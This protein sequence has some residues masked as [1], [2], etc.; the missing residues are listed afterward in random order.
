MEWVEIIGWVAV[1]ATIATYAVRTMLPLRLLALLAN[2]FFLIYGAVT[3]IYPTM[4]MYALL[5][6]INLYRIYDIQRT[7][8]LMKE[9]KPDEKAF[10]WLRPLLKPVRMFDGAYVF[11]MGD[12]ANR[13]F[14]M[15]AGEVLLEEI[16]VTLKGEQIFGE[17]GFFSEDLERAVSAKCIGPC[18][19]MSVDEAAFMRLFNQNP[20]FG[21][22]MLKLT[23]TRLVDSLRQNPDVLSQTSARKS[24]PAEETEGLLLYQQTSAAKA[25]RSSSVGNMIST[26]ALQRRRIPIIR[27]AAERANAAA[28]PLRTATE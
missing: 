2:L 19:I 15:L 6:P 12:P 17:I 3:P 10:E 23:A 9:I 22:Y 8:K 24:D 1:L 13:F 25:E 16:D 27:Q 11:R 21:L 4:V 28:S 26:A 7:T 14:V 5:L 20:A 18:E